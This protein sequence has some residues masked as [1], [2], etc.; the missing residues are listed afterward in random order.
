MSTSYSKFFQVGK[1]AY[2]LKTSS[3]LREEIKVMSFFSRKNRPGNFDIK[4]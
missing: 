3:P 4:F 2:S 1:R